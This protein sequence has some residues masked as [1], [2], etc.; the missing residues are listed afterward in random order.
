[1]RKKKKIRRKRERTMDDREVGSG[2][3]QTTPG[4]G[5]DRVD[6]EPSDR[7]PTTELY[8]LLGLEDISSAVGT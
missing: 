5:C 1:M 4:G 7:V 8:A 2:N 3:Q 6:D